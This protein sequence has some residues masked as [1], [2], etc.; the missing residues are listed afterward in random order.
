M[1]ARSAQQIWETALGELEIEVNRANYNTW[2]SGTVGLSCEGE[3]FVVGVPSTFVAEFL[4]RNLCSLIEKTLTGLTRREVK[5]R[6]HVAAAIGRPL[7]KP[8]PAPLFNPAYTFA[9]FVPG[10][11]NS[12]ARAAALDVAETPGRA[13]NPL[14]LHGPSGVGKT[15][16]LHAIGNEAATRG[17]DVLCVSAEQ[18]T[19]ELVAAIRDGR[20]A[21]FRKRFRSVDMLLVDDVQFFGGKEHTKENFFHTFNDLHSAGRQITMTCDRPP[22]SIPH[23]QA[24]LRSRF[25]WGLVADLLPPDFETRRAVLSAKAE[26]DGADLPPDVIEFIALQIKENMRVL[27]GSLNRV[28]AY[29]RLLKTLATPDLAARALDSI[30]C[31]EAP[32]VPPSPA[33]IAEAV[34][35]GFSVNLSDIKSR[36]RDEATVLA[37]QVSMYLIRQE[38]ECSLAEI[39]RE[40]GGRSPATI[41]YGY[42]KIAN[43]INNDPQLRRHVFNIQQKLHTTSRMTPPPGT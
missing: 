38:T 43:G 22:A 28:V 6:F 15:H 1:T 34:A 27:E 3:E 18:F 13:Y 9:S 8:R 12:M 30:A 7:A 23:I 11:C 20:T 4:N 17:M 26:R 36:K 42:D 25:E 39:G 37:R 16:L 41:S 33:L 10:R 40:M 21:E 2:L 24:R 5:A 31:K 14:F 35:A 29:A 19:N 32:P